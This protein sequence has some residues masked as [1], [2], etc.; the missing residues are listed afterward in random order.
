VAPAGS[1]GGGRSTPA[2]DSSL[3]T[4]H[5][6]PAA[7]RSGARIKLTSKEKR[8]LDALPLDISALETEQQ[9][10]ASRMSLP[11]YFKQAPLALRADQARSAE[12][13]KQLMAKLERWEELEAKAKAAAS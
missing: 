3:I 7:G 4:H 5:S 13:E 1:R 2:G 11:D 10:L 9:S 12:I 6:S 8:E